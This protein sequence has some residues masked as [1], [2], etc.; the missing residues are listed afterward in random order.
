M[1][2]N[3]LIW[4]EFLKL[5]A[6]E[7]QEREKHSKYYER[8]EDAAV[9][10]K[11]IL[12]KHAKYR[13]HGGGALSHGFR[14]RSSFGGSYMGISCSTIRD[15]SQY[16]SRRGT[17]LDLGNFALN[18]CSTDDNDTELLSVGTGD[19]DNSQGG[20]FDD[21]SLSQSPVN[22]LPHLAMSD[23]NCGM[24][25]I[26]YNLHVNY[27]IINI[28]YTILLSFRSRK[29]GSFEEHRPSLVTSLDSATDILTASKSYISGGVLDIRRY[30]LI[31]VWFHWG[32]DD[33][34]GS[35]HTVNFKAYPMEVQLIHWNSDE[36]PTYEEALGCKDGVVITSIFVQIGR[37]NHGFNSFLEFLEDI[38]F[39]MRSKTVSEPHWLNPN[40]FLPSGDL[41]DYWSYIGSTTFP[42]ISEEV[43]WI[44]YRYPLTMSPNQMAQFRTLRAF[45]REDLPGF[46][47]GQ[48]CD[49]FRPCQLLGD[50]IV[51][52]SFA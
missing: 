3:K 24:L 6:E 46:T 10:Y 37:E 31:E 47:E 8:A 28:G 42:P 5:R 44:V 40:C 26:Q 1:G 16:S 7:A 50:R 18:H 20:H 15:R 4:E 29:A 33:S 27:D 45:T 21:R 52:S 25:K 32:N 41:R 39:M 14:C 35:E 12:S 48:M 22:L 36:F 17:L 2:A 49:N 13:R 23:P 51:K 38:H 43:T 34:R 11:F 9:A 30:E 19:S